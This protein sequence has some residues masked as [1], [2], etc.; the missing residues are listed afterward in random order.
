MN[1]KKIKIHYFVVT[2]IVMALGLL[3][4]LSACYFASMKTIDKMDRTFTN[5]TRAL[6]TVANTVER[7]DNKKDYRSGDVKRIFMDEFGKSGFAENSGI[8]PRV[9]VGDEYT[10]LTLLKANGKPV[11][12]VK[13]KCQK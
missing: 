9:S 11:I 4:L 8:V 7:L 10:E 2:E 6:Q 12:E 3:M 5:D 1:R 13:I